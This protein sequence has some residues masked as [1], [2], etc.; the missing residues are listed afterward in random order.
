MTLIIRNGV[1]SLAIDPFLSID[2]RPIRVLGPTDVYKY[3]GISFTPVEVRKTAFEKLSSVLSNVSRAPLKPQQRLRMLRQNVVPK[4][5]HEL[6]L[7]HASVAYLRRIDRLVRSCVRRWLRLPLDTPL[8]FFHAPIREGGLGIASLLLTAP[9]HRRRRFLKVGASTDPCVQAVS[10]DE[11]TWQWVH[12]MWAKPVPRFRGQTSTSTSEVKRVLAEDLHSAIDGRGLAR[13]SLVPQAHHWLTHAERFN[14][15]AAAFRACVKLR[16]NLLATNSRGARGRAGADRLCPADL[17][18]ETLN[19][20]VQHCNRAHGLRVLRHDRVQNFLVGKLRREGWLVESEPVIRTSEG[21]RKPDCI[22]FDPGTGNAWV[23]DSQVC[24]E[25]ADPDMVFQTKVDKY[26]KPEISRF[27]RL[28]FPE[29]REVLFGAF[30]V[31]WR[32][33]IAPRTAEL[34]RSFR[35]RHVLPLVSL[36]ALEGGVKIWRAHRDATWVAPPR[37]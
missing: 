28:L 10:S 2:G 27:A 32:G 23:L 24:S 21:L 16:G 35:L 8:G 12:D 20:I 1:H 17:Q 22:A 34:L 15:T 9:I 3:L 4:V 6:S 18:P 37:R 26:S 5:L 19:H 11:S 29:A 7:T 25:Q 13:A 30:I 36:I 14:Q 31:S 33:I